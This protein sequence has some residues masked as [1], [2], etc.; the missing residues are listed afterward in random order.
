MIKVERLYFALSRHN[1]KNPD[2][3][4][5]AHWRHT[6]NIR[7]GFLSVSPNRFAESPGTTTIDFSLQEKILQKPVDTED[8]LS[9]IRELSKQIN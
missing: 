2:S 3:Q 9:R 1:V 4:Q 6:S 7:Y 8:L 5:T